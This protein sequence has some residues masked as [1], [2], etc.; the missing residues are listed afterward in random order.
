MITFDEWCAEIR[1]KNPD[2][3]IDP[4]LRTR[5]ND[6]RGYK[7]RWRTQTLSWAM[8]RPYHNKIDGECCMDFSCCFPD[9]FTED[10]EK[11]WEYYR[12]KFGHPAMSVSEKGKDNV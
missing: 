3:Y 9:M 11:R 8:G 7:D 10:T 12:N 5:F 4:S 1:E 6:R 2:I